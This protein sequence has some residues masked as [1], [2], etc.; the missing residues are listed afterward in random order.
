MDR[1]I[2]RCAMLDVHKA[3]AAA[4]VRVP[5]GDGVRRQE[6]REFRTSTAELIT[7]ADWL[8]AGRRRSLGWSPPACTGGRCSTC[9][10][11]VRVPAVQR[12]TFAS[13][14]RGARAMS[15]APS[16]LSAG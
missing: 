5:V 1:L 9:S 7:F 11:T 15:K 6:I 13:R 10:T 14:S 2:E 16:G 8:A 4:C 3:Q 12:E